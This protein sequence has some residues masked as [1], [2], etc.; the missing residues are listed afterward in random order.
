MGS[1]NTKRPSLK[2]KFEE[3]VKQ[4][5][6]VG[7]DRLTLNN[8]HLAP[9]CSCLYLYYKPFRESGTHAPRCGFAKVTVNG[10]YV[11]LHFNVKAIKFNFLTFAFSDNSGALFEGTETDFMPDWIEKFE[12]KNNAADFSQL[13]GV[14]DIFVSIASDEEKLVQLKELIDVDSFISFWAMESLMGFWDGYYADQNNF[15]PYRHT[16]NNKLYLFPGELIRHSPTTC[17]SRPVAFERGPSMLK[18]LCLTDSIALTKPTRPTD[19]D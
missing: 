14:A 1:L 8:N 12:L 17:R 11:G 6:V 19:L 4:S 9:G 18:P 2:I 5:L 16:K 15:Y 10:D 3:Y 13:R 7:L